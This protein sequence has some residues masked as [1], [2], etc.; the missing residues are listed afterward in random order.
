MASGPMKRS[1]LEWLMSRSCQRVTFSSAGMAAARTTRARPVRFSD[2][3]GLRLWGMAAA[4]LLAGVEEFLGF[5]DL[6]ALEVTHFRWRG[7]RCR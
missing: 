3:T 1:T 6:A 7:A 4:A 5:A 2:S